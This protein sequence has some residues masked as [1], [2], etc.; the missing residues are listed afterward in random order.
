M[1][2]TATTNP[3]FTSTSAPSESRQ[4]RAAINVGD[5]ERM[6]SL[7][8]GGALT[9]LGLSRR[10]LGGLALA[11]VGGS[12]V[13]RGMTGHCSLYQA[14]DLNTAGEPGP[15]TAVRAGHGCKVE[16][17]LT[18]NRPPADL[19]RFFRDFTNLPRFMQHVE[20][21]TTQG[22]N[23][24]HWVVS[25]PM[26][27]RV[28]WDAEIHN[29]RPNE[30]IAWRSLEGSQVDTAGSIHFE[31]LP[32]GRGTQVRVILKYDPPA[33]KIGAMATHLLGRSAEQM[34]REDLYRFKQQ[35]ETGQGASTVGQ[36]Q[37][38]SPR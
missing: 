2:T 26:S 23:R 25:G 32:G 24:S 22:P 38:T 33:G 9:V 18:I 7:I 27:M 31:A 17:S 20:S 13:Y 34:I 36:P 6:L 4:A 35:M 3:Q 8:G 21:I 29:E 11:A 10:S 15:A 14:L 16:E 30:L 37:G 19:Y 1:A 5:A 28:E 12:L